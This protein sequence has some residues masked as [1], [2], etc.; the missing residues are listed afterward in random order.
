M[1]QSV[2]A[3]PPRT[4]AEKRLGDIL[5]C[6]ERHLSNP[7]LNVAAVARACGISSRYLCAILKAHDIRFSEVLWKSR[8]EHT[9]VWLKSDN[10]RHVSITKIAYMAGFKS[11]AHFSRMFKQVMSVTPGEFR[12]A[13][14]ALAGA[15]HTDAAQA[16]AAAASAGAARADRP[17][18][19][20]RM[21]GT[22]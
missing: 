21:R 6:T 5:D 7:D 3:R 9:K 13:A 22:H 10:M 12:Q 11:A 1:S 14:P 20:R 16:D 2:H 17:L 19:I 4:L 15:V 18:Q 8:L